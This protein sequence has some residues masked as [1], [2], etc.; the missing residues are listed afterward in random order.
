L[1]Y[2]S[3]I[4]ACLTEARTRSASGEHTEGVQMLA[5]AVRVFLDALRHSDTSANDDS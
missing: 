3:R 5:V 1:A 4:D 2:R